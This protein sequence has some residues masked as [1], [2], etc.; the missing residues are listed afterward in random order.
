MSPPALTFIRDLPTL[1]MTTSPSADIEP[2]A[3]ELWLAALKQLSERQAAG[4]ANVGSLLRHAFHLLQLTPLPL[5]GIVRCQLDEEGFEKL[6]EC[7]A[8]D[9]AAIALVGPPAGFSLR[10]AIGT[11]TRVF[12]AAVHL[13]GQL[14]PSADARSDSAASALVGAWSNCLLAIRQRLPEAPAPRPAPHRQPAELHPRS[15][16]P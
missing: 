4:G 1:P 9:A 10:C 7:G 3:P 13:P 6:L 5:R 11:R 12:E 2:L 16:E 14:H 15:I 8:F